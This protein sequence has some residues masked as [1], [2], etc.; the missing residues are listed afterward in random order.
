[1]GAWLGFVLQDL[2]ERNQVVPLL[3]KLLE[4][5]KTDRQGTEGFGDWCMR[6]GV[7]RLCGMLG[8]PLAK[9]G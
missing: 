7:E 6:Q 1:V 4:H 3:Q 2:V 8:V 5:V 9:A